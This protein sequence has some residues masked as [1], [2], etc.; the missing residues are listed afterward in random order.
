MFVKRYP[1]CVKQRFILLVSQTTIYLFD[2]VKKFNCKQYCFNH[3]CPC[4]FFFFFFFFFFLGPNPQHMEVH[5]LGV[6]SEL[7]L[8]AYTTATQDPSHICYLHHSSQ[9]RLIPDPLSKARDQTCLLMGTSQICFCHTTT[10][11][12]VHVS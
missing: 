2:L 7:Q 11:T 3:S 10:G 9:Q 12:S 1:C 6:I 5:R 4:F 8:P